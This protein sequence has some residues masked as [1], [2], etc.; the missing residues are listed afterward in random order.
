MGVP[1]IAIECGV[2]RLAGVDGLV[3]VREG[4][5]PLVVRTSRGFGEVVFVAI[6]LNV[7][8][9]AGWEGRSR[10]LGKLITDPAADKALLV[11]AF[12]A[13][14]FMHEVPRWLVVVVISRDVM[15][16]CGYFLL[17]MMTGQT[18]EVRPSVWGKLST[19]LQLLAVS[20]VLVSLVRPSLVAP[21]VERLLFPLSGIV[22]AVA[23]LQ[24]MYRGLVWL[25]RSGE[26]LSRGA[27]HCT[28]V[29]ADPRAAA[30]LRENVERVGMREQGTTVIAQ[31]G[32]WRPPRGTAYTLVV[33]DP[34][35]DDAAAWH[36]RPE[37]ENTLATTSGWRTPSTAASAAPDDMP[38][39]QTRAGST[40]CRRRTLR[41]IAAT[42]AASP[43]P[44]AVGP[45]NQFQHRSGLAPSFWW[46]SSTSA[47]SASASAT[48]RVPRARS[49]AVCRQPW[50]RTMSGASRA[51]AVAGT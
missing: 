25:H 4:D 31:V 8:P 13:L 32:R 20:V 34:P 36:A 42:M 49:S 28:F 37:C 18:M 23:G 12:I 6:D 29:E 11:S 26:A 22:T 17:F 43:C 38:A 30:V 5:V 3:E 16:V 40:P 50:I 33:A 35:Y 45:S 7:P 10:L 39:T 51:A 15:I 24:Y 14:G 48:I 41:I 44:A 47:P 19:A 1:R 2:P 46:G 9:L 21:A 27:E